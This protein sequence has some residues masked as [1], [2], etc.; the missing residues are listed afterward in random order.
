MGATMTTTTERQL[1]RLRA[2]FEERAHDLASVGFILR[3]SILRRFS[4]CGSP[5]SRRTPTD[6][7]VA[8]WLQV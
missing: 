3:G 2:R 6:S 7:V 4:R 5:V 8:F 1:A